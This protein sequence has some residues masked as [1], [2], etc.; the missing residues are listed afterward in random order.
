MAKFSIVLP[1]R[2]GGNYVKECVNSILAQT[3]TDFNLVVLDNCSTDGTLEWIKGLTDERILVYPATESLGIEKNWARIV[4]VPRNEFMTC[5]GH[6][7]VLAPDYLSVMNTLVERYPTASLYQAH[8]TYID[9]EGKKIKRCRPMKERLSGAE[10]LSAI[11]TRSIDIIGTGFLARSKDYDA[12]GGIPPYPSLLFADFELWFRLA[13]IS[14]MVVAKEACFSFRLHQS[15]TG[16]APDSRMQSAFGAFMR[17][18]AEAQHQ[19][20]SYAEVIHRDAGGFLLFYCKS[21]SHRLLRTAMDK[22]NNITVKEFVQRTR[23]LAKAFDPPLVYGPEKVLSIK[24]ALFIDS[25]ALLRKCFL[26]FKKMY[27]KPVLNG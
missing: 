23:E 4:G 11:L 17:F 26:L 19:N 13:G 5:I 6:D 24:M 2:N 8:F 7:D 14:D 3:C 15:T 16:A 20:A 22:R 21:L 18:L 25:N 9:A 27:S 1:V 12:I 10:F